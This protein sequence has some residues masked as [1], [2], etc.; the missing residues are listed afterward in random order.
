MCPAGQRDGVDGASM[1]AFTWNTGNRT[2]LAEGR[3]AGSTGVEAE[4]VAANIDRL[5]EEARE[6][7]TKMGGQASV[8]R[9]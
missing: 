1:Q 2:E 6:N 5:A 3:I 7:A 4:V 9:A 8:T